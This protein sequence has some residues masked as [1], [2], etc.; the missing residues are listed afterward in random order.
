MRKRISCK[1][2]RTIPL[3]KSSSELRHSSRS[4]DQ[5]HNISDA[6]ARTTNTKKWVWGTAANA[7]ERHTSNSV[8]YTD[9]LDITKMSIDDCLTAHVLDLYV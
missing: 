3:S 9:R 5:F 8:T 6:G 7:Q 2:I 1:V 4:N